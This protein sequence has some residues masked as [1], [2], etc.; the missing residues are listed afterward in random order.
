MKQ[1]PLIDLLGIRSKRS[2]RIYVATEPWNRLSATRKRH[3]QK[4]RGYLTA[5]ENDALG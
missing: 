4:D 2:V 1:S 3:K 5:D